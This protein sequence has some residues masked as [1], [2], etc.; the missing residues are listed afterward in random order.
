M[1][2]ISSIPG[3]VA[4]NEVEHRNDTQI[5]DIYTIVWRW[6]LSF[7]GWC[8]ETPGMPAVSIMGLYDVQLDD[9]PRRGHSS[10]PLLFQHGTPDNLIPANTS[11]LS[12][13][14]CFGQSLSPLALNTW[15]TAM[16]H[17]SPLTNKYRRC[18]AG[19]SATA[20]E[21]RVRLPHNRFAVPSGATALTNAP[22]LLSCLSFRTHH[23]S[24]RNHS[25]KRSI[26]RYCR[27]AAAAVMR[28]GFYDRPQKKKTANGTLGKN[29]FC[30]RAPQKEIIYQFS[31]KCQEK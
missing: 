5:R 24:V 3:I 7:F 12:A 18:R 25:C 17:P 31:C 23:G 30:W 29:T 1:A 27:A 6:F 16:Q 21:Q 14:D 22:T 2:P 4:G 11:K 28:T 26:Q 15:R 10:I 8:R 19:V 20:R 9:F 13:Q